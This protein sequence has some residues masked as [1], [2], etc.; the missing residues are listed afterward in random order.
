MTTKQVIA[1][2]SI[3]AKNFMNARDYLANSKIF[4]KIQFNVPAI[5]DITGG[6]ITINSITQIY[7]EAG[8]GKSQLAMQLA[9]NVQLP[10]NLGG[11]NGNCVYVSTDKRIETKR[12]EAMAE[13][14]KIKN[15]YE[16]AIRKIDFLDNIIVE[17]FNT[18]SR[19]KSFV[20]VKLPEILK[21][22]P[23]VR[24]VVMTRCRALIAQSASGRT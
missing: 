9:V 23:Y 10:E 14:L 8:S 16:P 7:G 22:K 21:Q 20:C 13:E 4:R 24:L 2:K 3:H 12:I 17:E 1:I 5:D 11:L 19:F 18:T 6:G 15:A